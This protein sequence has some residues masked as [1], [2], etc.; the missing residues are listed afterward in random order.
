MSTSPVASQ[1]IHY[2]IELQHAHIEVRLL[3]NDI[4]IAR[5]TA[6]DQKIVSQRVNGWMLC[7]GNELKLFAAIPDPAHLAGPVDLKCLVFRGPHGRQPEESEALARFAERDKQKFP[8]GAMQELWKTSFASDPCY[9]PWSWEYGHPIAPDGEATAGAMHAINSVIATL[10][11]QDSAQLQQLFRVMTDESA[12]A[13][14]IKVERAEAQLAA[15]CASWT[16]V[17]LRPLLPDDFLLTVEGNHRLLRIERKDGNSVFT[18]DT[19]FP[20]PGQRRI[21]LAHLDTGWTIVR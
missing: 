18:A 3:L 5:G 2:V 8:A 13:Y 19:K 16:A 12:L 7:E 11:V 10:N 17:P 20:A 21:Y 14:G 9:G 6:A 1:K 15:W 4:E